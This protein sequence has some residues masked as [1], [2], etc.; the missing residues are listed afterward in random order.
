LV[1][2]TGKYAIDYAP[3]TYRRKAATAPGNDELS[4]SDERVISATRPQPPSSSWYITTGERE[5]A[6]VCFNALLELVVGEA[7]NQP[8]LVSK[9]SVSVGQWLETFRELPVVVFGVNRPSVAV[10]E[11]R[12]GVEFE[13][14]AKFRG[15]GNKLAILK[16][17]APT[18]RA[19][20]MG[21]RDAQSRPALPT[22]K[23]R[24]EQASPLKRLQGSGWNH[25]RPSAADG[26]VSRPEVGRGDIPAESS[27]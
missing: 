27:N 1:R 17:D 13:E 23:I 19:V 9:G 21:E 7:A 11:E 8:H 22:R 5:G 3:P 6:A 12:N 16:R 4:A 20:V 26:L 10:A 2:D 18:A 25:V 24:G 14:L 15:T